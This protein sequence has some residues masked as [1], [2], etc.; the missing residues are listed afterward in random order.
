[1]EWEANRNVHTLV[2]AREL[3]GSHAWRTK[4]TPRDCDLHAVDPDG[5]THVVDAW[6]GTLHTTRRL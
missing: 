1:M 4:H 2:V 5:H 6:E 3:T